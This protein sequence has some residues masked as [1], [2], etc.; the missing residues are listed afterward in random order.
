LYV[1][2]STTGLTGGNA[3]YQI[4]VRPVLFKQE[5]RI[6]LFNRGIVMSRLLRQLSGRN[7]SSKEK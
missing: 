4:T 5:Y 1:P 7:Q 6:R 3:K 2:D